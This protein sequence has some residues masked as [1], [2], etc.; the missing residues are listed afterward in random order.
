MSNTTVS[1][2]EQQAIDFANKYGVKLSVGT[3]SFGKHW[4]GD[5]ESR[6]IFPLK[7][8][9]GGKSYSFKFRQSIASGKKQPTLYEVLACLQK[10]DVGSY[11]DFCSAF[12]YDAY[13]S[14]SGNKSKS[15]FKTYTA[16]CK[17]YEAVSRLF[18]DTEI[19]ALQEIQ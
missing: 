19:E 3:P 6:W 13:D 7:L 16:V 15:S 4:E 14:F 18:S 5:K 2:Y 1:S 10:Y 12:G 11:E 9:K 8:S 17:E